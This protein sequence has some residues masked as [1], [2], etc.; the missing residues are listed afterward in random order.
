MADDRVMPSGLAAGAG[1]PPP[2]ARA[3]GEMLAEHGIDPDRG[4]SS[5]DA[6]RARDRHG[7]N[8]LEQ[9]PRRSSLARFAAQFRGL[10]VALLIGAAVIA[11][12]LG[13]H[14]NAAAILAIVVLNAVLGFVQEERAARALDTLRGLARPSARVLRDGVVS[15]IDPEELVPGDVLE[16]EAGDLVPADARLISAYG[17]RA[18]EAPLTGEAEPVDKDAVARLDA[19]TDLG[20][21]VNMIH[22]GTLLSAGKGSAL[23]TATGMRTEMGRIA[24]LLQRVETRPTPLQRRLDALGRVLLVVCVALVAAI[25]LAQWLRGG[26]P[27]EVLFLAVS[28]AVAAVPEGLPAVVTLALALGVQ[29]MARQKALVRHLPAVETL[30]SVSVI[31]SDKTGTLTRN[32]MTAD[33]VVAGGI[34]Y[35]VTGAGYEPHGEFHRVGAGGAVPDLRREPELRELLRIGA[36]CNHAVIEPAI[37]VGHW[38]VIGDPTEAALRAL[39]LKGH[40]AAPGQG[41]RAVFE[42]PFEPARRAMSIVYRDEAG[43]VLLTTK[44]APEA[45]LPRCT[46]ERVSGAIVEMTEGRR[47]E[48]LEMNTR[49]AGRALR[50]LALASRELAE[51]DPFEER[52]LVFAGLVGMLDPP[53]DEAFQAVADCRASGI[54]PVM[55]TG[56]HPETALAIARTLGIAGPDDRAVNG[57]DLDRMTDEELAGRIESLPVYARVSAEHKLR[58][59]HAWRAR[60]HVVAMTG[61]GVN[62]APAVQAADIGIAMGRSGTD[63]TREAADMVLLDDNFA[64]IVRA[65]REGRAIFDNIQ[66]FVHYLLS[67][68]AGEILFMFIAA[69]AGWPAPLV[70]VQI[71]WINLV[72]DGLPALALGVEPPERDVMERAP[73]PVHDPVVS[74]SHGAF[75]VARGALVA[76]AAGIGFLL[77]HRAD[78]ANLPQARTVAFGIVAYSQLLYAFAFRSQRET[79]P[80]LGP[81]SNRAL[82]GAVAAAALLQLAAIELPVARPLFETVRPGAEQWVMIALLSLA[83]V[84]AVEVAKIVRE[85]WRRR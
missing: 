6:A 45:I 63:V 35:R 41:E 50:V 7:L 56:D 85:A 67:T 65:V 57:H 84:S 32:E 58:V 76:A 49:L 82:L 70:A 72:T 22:M 1:A 39:A 55:I 37:E 48:L 29:R 21:R 47:R 9:G 71:L 75:I 36:L 17:L 2:H 30:G 34:E 27:A 3:A 66:K 54:R 52:D 5:W 68:N 18:Q 60:G 80:Q 11:L 59:V 64:T 14:M 77:T 26:Q 13:E 42:I 4:L 24:T 81:F 33:T 62:D 31:C 16:V 19:V 44:G 69:L 51:G 28:L 23:V 12:A 43:R 15:R 46:S 79:L 8:R 83:P 74:G 10:V 25:A 38:T 53:R 73:R 40:V 61:D 20:D 78:D